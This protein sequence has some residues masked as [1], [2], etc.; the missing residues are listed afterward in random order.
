MHIKFN[1]LNQ[2]EPLV[3]SL[4]NPG[5]QYNESTHAPTRI[6]GV[7]SDISDDE[8]ILS[9]STTS[10][11]NFRAYKINHRS[12]SDLSDKIEIEESVSLFD[13]IENRRLIFIKDIGYFVIEDV[14]YGYDVSGEYKDVKASSVES[15][16]RGKKVPYIEDNTYSFESLLSKIVPIQDALAS[17]S[18]NPLIWKVDKN[19]PGTLKSKYRTFEDVDVE[20]DRLSFLIENMQEAYECIFEFDIIYRIVRVY[21]QADYVRPTDIHLTRKD[22]INSISIAENSDDLYTALSVLGGN[23]ETISSINPLGSNV[24]YDFTYYLPWMS[25]GL[26]KKVIAW[27]K[28]IKDNEQAYYEASLGYFK[29]ADIVADY[30]MEIDRLESLKATYEKCMMSKTNPWLKSLNEELNNIGK[31]LADGI[32]K[33]SDKI[34][35]SISRNYGKY[36]STNKKWIFG[37]DFLNWEKYKGTLKEPSNKD[38]IIAKVADFI[39]DGLILVGAD[40]FSDANVTSLEFDAGIKSNKVQQ[41]INKSKEE[42]EPHETKMETYKTTMDNIRTKVN[43]ATFFDK[44]MD[45]LNFFVF[46]GNYKDDYVVITDQMSQE[47]IFKQLQIMLGRARLTLSKASHPTQEFS[48]DVGNFIFEKEF[49]PWSDQLET[50]RAINIEIE[51][52]DTAQLFLTNITVNY[53]DQ[54][55]SLTFGNR[56]DRFDTKSVFEKVLGGISRSSNSINFIK[57]TM[58]PI[59]NGELDRVKKAIE[60]ARNLSIG[61]AL[62]A[63]DEEVVIDGSGYLGRKKLEDGSFDP[64]QIKITG[65]NIL[66]TND[67]WNSCAT[68]IGEIFIDTDQKQTAY[69]VNAQYLIG[70]AIFGQNLTIR[71]NNSSVVIDKNGIAIDCTGNETPF[72]IFKTTRDDN[73]NITSTKD[74][75]VMDKNG[76]LKISGSGT[77]AGWNIGTGA[78]AL[79]VGEMT[80]SAI[81]HEMT[82]TDGTKYSIGLQAWFDDPNSSTFVNFYV[83]SKDNKPNAKWTDVFYVKNDGKLKATNAEITGSITASSFL[84]SDGTTFTQGSSSPASNNTGFQLTSGG[85]LTASNATIYGTIKASSFE[86]LGNATLS[87]GDTPANNKTGFKVDK[88]GKLSASTAEIWGTIKASSFELLGEATLSRGPTPGEDT[89][90]FRVDKNGKLEAS[91]AEIWGKITASQGSIGGWNIGVGSLY[92]KIDSTGAVSSTSST[93]K[94]IYAND[95]TYEIG[96]KADFNNEANLNYYVYKSEKCV[97]GIGNNGTVLAQ[98]ITVGPQSENNVTINGTTGSANI[99]C[100]GKIACKDFSA[101]GEITCKDFSTTGKIT[102]ENIVGTDKITFQIDLSN[103]VFDVFVAQKINNRTFVQLPQLPT[104]TAS[105]AANVFVNQNGS[106]YKS[107]S[108]SRRYKTQIS[109][110]VS[111]ELDPHGLYEIPVVEYIYKEGYLL[112]DDINYGKKVIGIIA[113]DVEEYYPIAA[114]YNQDGLV[115]N[116][117]ERFIVPGML[118]LIQ[119]QHEQITK[120]QSQVSD[121]I[122]K[123]A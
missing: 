74:L 121:L 111:G 107:T 33:L 4:C 46:E 99:N 61:N 79:K 91:S 25:E 11:L 6:L 52:G 94:G 20:K 12:D 85:Q 88:N 26:R 19:I 117:N 92:S 54:T 27:Q 106:L 110:L 96:M 2:Y 66:F 69:G 45:E 43:M 67:N 29:E 122:A 32:K 59:K 16:L 83:K 120:L 51:D 56:L 63:T 17:Q 78:E 22:L 58:Y 40:L 44:Y 82:A 86:L 41:D 7:L 34:G 1:S 116:W 101:T 5:S 23:N 89:T 75:L 90:G 62:S 47:E 73:N 80:P 97:F 105:D 68:A 48:V 119:E 70:E 60:D 77:I 35:T 109:E 36:D 115:E 24:I 37:Y 15:E 28:L 123:S 64:K 118:K 76:K 3:V 84:L 93:V 18:D 9:F 102:T 13:K 39:V 114:S 30:D 10:E 108:S 72:K 49:K 71:N 81:Y 103:S 113:E 65:K 112:Q 53:Q 95:T 57:D 21:D 104:C 50:G 31:A 100:K 55:L 38:Q 14:V 42:R 87:R 98:Y 8:L